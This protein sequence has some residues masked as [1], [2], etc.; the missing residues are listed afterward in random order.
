[1]SAF[2]YI[3][4]KLTIA[5]LMIFLP[6][7]II[8]GVISL[9]S[10]LKLIVS[11]IISISKNEK[12]K[13][14]KFYKKTMLERNIRNS[15]FLRKNKYNRL[16]KKRGGHMRNYI[17]YIVLLAFII[18][19]ALLII[20]IVNKFSE[21]EVSKVNNTVSTEEK[22]PIQDNSTDSSS[23]T[24]EKEPDQNN[25]N[26]ST[27]QPNETTNNVVVPNT[28]AS[29]NMIYTIIG[30]LTVSLGMIYIKKQ[31]KN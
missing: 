1:M 28:G 9:C 8:G 4:L 5:L 29:Q 20:S 6:C 11:K 12:N 21:P 13:N 25:S 23:S 27:T 3:G 17:R 24:N 2:H 7:I 30:V 31:T 22:E 10:F 18:A 14:R 19:G 15:W 26:Q 16:R